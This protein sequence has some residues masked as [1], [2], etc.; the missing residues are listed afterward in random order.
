MNYISKYSEWENISEATLDDT[1]IDV[2]YSP[3]RTGRNV[4]D[5]LGIT[6]NLKLTQTGSK[7]KDK[8]LVLQIRQS[9]MK[10][11]EFGDFIRINNIEDIDSQVFIYDTTSINI[12]Y[13]VA[14]KGI[15]T[16]MIKQS[17]RTG[18]S[19]RGN[20][21]RETAFIITFAIRLWEEKSVKIDI[22]SNRGK[23][24][25]DFIP[26]GKAIMSKS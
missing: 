4:L 7:P 17:N 3:S 5:R 8:E 11:I 20:Y 23:I 2:D 24:K 10:L 16:T 9:S 26:N 12:P 21:F 19:A 1:K 18:A 25:L 13:A 15:K 22:Y 14:I 6:E